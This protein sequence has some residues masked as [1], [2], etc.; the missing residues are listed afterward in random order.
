METIKAFEIGPSRYIDYDYA[1][2]AGDTFWTIATS[3][4]QARARR[5]IWLKQLE[6][7]RGN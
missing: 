6:K 7:I 5:D 1:T 4:G 3:L 2:E